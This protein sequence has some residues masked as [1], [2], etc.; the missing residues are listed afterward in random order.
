MTNTLWSPLKL[1][2]LLTKGV[3][4]SKIPPIHTGGPVEELFCMLTGS[5]NCRIQRT[6]Q[7]VTRHF[8]NLMLI[9]KYLLV[10]RPRRVLW[11][12]Y[13][14]SRNIMPAPKI[15]HK[16]TKLP[17]HRTAVPVSS[18]HQIAILERPTSLSKFKRSRLAARKSF[19]I[20]LRTTHIFLNS[21]IYQTNLIPFPDTSS[22]HFPAEL[23]PQLDPK[24]CGN[25]GYSPPVQLKLKE[26]LLGN[27]VSSVHRQFS[28][29]KL[30]CIK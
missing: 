28:G 1:C 9:P 12:V 23:S 26:L 2:F 7:I 18:Q 16:A 24:T 29:R 21:A 3:E 19:I 10:P 11:E 27:E 22:P 20:H 14:E 5:M 30:V 8:Q 13:F 4:A 17:Q 15:A 6:R 25:S